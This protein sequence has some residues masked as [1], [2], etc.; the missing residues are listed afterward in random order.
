MKTLI[1]EMTHFENMP[2]LFFNVSYGQFFSTMDSFFNKHITT[3]GE[4]NYKDITK[5]ELRTITELIA[6]YD[7]N[8]KTKKTISNNVAC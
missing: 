6:T 8:N 2:F 4:V 5:D 3:Q 7:S 1:V